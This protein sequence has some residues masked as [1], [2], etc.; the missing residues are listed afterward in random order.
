MNAPGELEYAEAAVNGITLRYLEQGEGPLI[1]LLHG[2]P[3]LGYSW[4]HQLGPLA[5]AGYHVVAPDLRGYGGSSAPA[6]V[7]A[8]TYFDIIGD[9]AALMD[10]LGHREAVVAG[11]DMGSYVAWHMALVLPRRV[12]GVAGLSVA[13]RRRRPE[14]PLRVL[15]AAFGPDFYQVRFQQPEITDAELAG[16]V[17][18]FLPGIFAGLSADAAEP[19]ESLV[20]PPGQGFADLFPAPASLPGWID[21][22]EMAV[23]AEAFR[24]TGFTGALNWYRNTDRNWALLAP[25]AGLPVEPPAIYVAGELDIAYRIAAASGALADMEETVADLRDTVV[26]P[27]CG[28]WVNQERPEVVNEALLGLL[29]VAYGRRAA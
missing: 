1:L 11:H 22:G 23:Y 12:C 3:E 14:P 8:Y 7:D 24:R 21:E 2:F 6:A 26:V 16:R 15:E 20:I 10:E 28:H 18:E 4:R 13:H 19:I 17:E 27:D 25:W 29:E 9:L 5:A